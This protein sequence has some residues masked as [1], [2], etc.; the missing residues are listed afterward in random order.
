MSTTSST[1]ASDPAATSPTTGFNSIFQS[2]GGPPL[3][4]VCIAAGLLLGAFVGMVLM[5]RLRPV[6]V[7]QRVNGVP[8]GMEVKLWEKPQL[9]DVHIEP[10]LSREGGGHPWAHISPFA[11]VYLPH[12]DSG[13]IAPPSPHHRPN[14]LAR[15]AARLHRSQRPGKGHVPSPPPSPELREVQLAVAVTMPNPALH[16]PKS[17]DVADDDCHEDPMPDCCIGTA[18][19]PYRPALVTV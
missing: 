7:V 14:A 2:A 5:K 12:A 6:P 9:Y 4:L 16:A 13:A 17:V 19:L 15:L 1:S 11:A 10:P 8:I 18:V 3:I